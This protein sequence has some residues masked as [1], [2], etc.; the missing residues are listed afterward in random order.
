MSEKKHP[1]Q[2]FVEV[3]AAQPEEAWATHLIGMGQSNDVPRLF[4][5]TGKVHLVGEGSESWQGVSALQ[6]R[7]LAWM[8]C[9][10]THSRFPASAKV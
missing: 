4:R 8:R 9:A 1:I 2:D 7:G 6:Q 10:P 3:L 5:V